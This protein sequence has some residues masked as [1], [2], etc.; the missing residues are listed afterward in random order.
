M[1]IVI[2][3]RN[4]SPWSMRPRVLAREAGI[5]FEEVQLKF[6]AST[7]PAGIERYGVAGK[8]PVLVIDGEP[9]SDSLAIWETLA[10]RALRETEFVPEDEPYAAG[11]RK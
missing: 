3:N 4:Y 10:E 1:Q 2:G 7:K 6:D 11:H 8:V 5:P 9:V